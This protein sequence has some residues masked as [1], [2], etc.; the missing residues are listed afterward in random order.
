MHKKQKN[1][2][3]CSFAVVMLTAAIV[4]A[5]NSSFADDSS[6]VIDSLKFNYKI[7]EEL[8]SGDFTFTGELPVI[9]AKSH[10]QPQFF[11]GEEIKPNLDLLL[12]LNGKSYPI[13]IE[14]DCDVE[15]SNNIAVSVS[16]GQSASVTV[17]LKRDSHIRE[18]FSYIILPVQGYI[19][20]V[21]DNI[22]STDVS[23]EDNVLYL[24]SPDAH[25][26]FD[27][28]IPCNG[29]QMSD[30]IIS[31]DVLPADGGSTTDSSII[32]LDGTNLTIDTGAV[33]GS[34]K[35]FIKATDHEYRSFT[36][37]VYEMV[38]V[39]NSSGYYIPE[40]ENQDD[41]LPNPVITTIT[42]EEVP[43]AAEAPSTNIAIE[44]FRS[45][46]RLFSRFH[47]SKTTK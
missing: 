47:P 13:D 23:L 32:E 29:C 36:D 22:K 45:V 43:M 39:N 1:C 34:V 40:L 41:D 46:V 37:T 19:K 7:T 25:A 15:Y 2:T 4:M 12:C 30:G 35:L 5:Q 17:S 6:S 38:V 3:I 20:P 18:T 8:E 27:I 24:N 44:F 28:S 31:Y 26:E 16:S 42:D 14:H 9:S 11:T 33:D 10:I 21:L